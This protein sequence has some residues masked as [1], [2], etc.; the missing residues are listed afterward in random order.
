MASLLPYMVW[1]GK[2]NYH[3]CNTPHR[4]VQNFGKANFWRFVSLYTFG[5]ENFGGSFKTTLLFFI[6]GNLSLQLHVT[7]HTLIALSR[8]SFAMPTFITK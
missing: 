3:K 4:I 2:K 5:V 7:Y 6:H 8:C 1:E